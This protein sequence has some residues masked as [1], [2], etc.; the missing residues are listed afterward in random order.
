MSE[1]SLPVSAMFRIDAVCQAFEEAWQAAGEAGLRPRIEDYLGAT[2]QPERDALLGELLKVELHYRRGERPTPEEYRQRF[3]QD[4]DLIAQVFEEMASVPGPPREGGSGRET[5]RPAAAQQTGTDPNRT[6]PESP[7]QSPQGGQ[8]AGAATALPA[9]PGY[10][11]QGVLGRGGMGV[12]YKARDVQLNRLVALKMIL[13]GAH[14]GPQELAR[15]RTEAKAVARLQHP[16]VVQ[17]HEVGEHDG[18]PYFSLEFV[19]GGSL[20]KKLAGAPQQPGAAAQ[21]LETLARAVHAAHERGIVHRDL[22]P[23]NVLLTAD[24]VPKVTD[25]GLAKH[26]DDDSGGTLSGAILG[27]P[28]YMAPEQAAGRTKEIGPLSDV[29]ALGAILYEM[30]T[31]SPPFKGASVRDTLEQVC[32]QEPVPPRQL[33]PKV[34]RDLETICLKCLQKEP[35]RR[36]GSA[37]EL[38]ED[39]RR[40]QAG[41]PIQ[42]R[43]VGSAERAWRWCRR[44]PVVAGLLTAVAATLVVGS[45][46]ATY[47]AIQARDEAGHARDNEWRAEEE[48][49]NALASEKQA[50][51]AKGEAERARDQKDRQLTRAEGLVYAGRIERAQQYWRAGDVAAAQEQ[52]DRCRWDYRGWEHDY[53][54][55][56]FNASHLTLRGHTYAVYSVC[57]S[58]D[59]RRLASAS[60]HYGRGGEVK[61]WDAQTGQELLSLQGHGAGHEVTGVCFSPDGRRLASASTD[62]TVK[63]WN[64]Q[65]GQE[66]QTLKGHRGSVLSVCFSPDSR[67]L[68]SAS[69][70]TVKVWD[71]QTG[72]ELLTLEGAYGCVCFSPDG[73]RLASAST[74][75]TVKVWDAHTGREQRT[76]RLTTPVVHSVCFSPDGRRLAGAG[77]DG[78]RLAGAGGMMVKVWDAQTGQEQ[79]TLRGHTGEVTSV[80]F[81]PD[82]R[83]LAT[84]SLDRTVKVWDAQTGQEARSLQGHTMKVRSV[85]FSPDGRRLASAGGEPNEPGEVK[86]WDAQTGQ[87]QFSLQGAGGPVCFSP[88][89]RRLASASGDFRSRDIRKGEVKVWDARTGQEALSL[90]GHTGIVTSVC[91]SPDGRRLASASGGIDEQKRQGYGEVK[92]WDAQTGQELLSLQGHTSLVW[93]VCFSPDGRRLASAGGGDEVKVW[94]AQTGQELLTLEGAFGCV[95]FSPDGRRLATASADRTVRLWD[96]QTGQELL[97]LEGAI[98]CVCFSPD[99]RRLATASWDQTVKVWD[100]QTGQ[101]QLTLQGHTGPVTG[102]CFSPDGR[103]LASGSGDLFNLGNAW[104]LKV[105]DAQTGQETRPLQGHTGP[106][107]SV[108][109]SADGTRVVAA[110]PLGEVRSWDA[111]AGQLVV[112]DLGRGLTVFRVRSWDA[113]TGQLVVPCTDP[114]PPQPQAVS[115]DGQRVVRIDRGQPVVEPRAL[116][117]GDLFR[118]RLADPVGTHLWHLRLTREAQD[119]ADAFALAFHLEPLLLTSF[120]QRGARPRDA[121]PLWAVRPPLTRAPAGAAE[122]PVP[123]TEAEVQRLHDALSRR[124]DAEPKAWSLWAARGWSRHL[125]GDLAGAAAD[126]KRAAALQADEPG[127]WAVLG[128]VYLKHHQT[129]QAEGV[130]RKLAGSAG[131]DVAIWH[132]VEA[133]ACEQEGDWATAWWHVDH[134]LAGLP[135]PCP[136]LLVRRGRIALELGR[137]HDAAR[138]Y[139]AAVGLGRADVDTLSWSARV[140]LASGDREGYRQARAALLRQFDP[141]R[142]PQN[143][144]WV[145]RTALLGSA[146]GADL[147]PLREGLPSWWADPAAQAT[148]FLPGHRVLGRQPNW[149]T[150][151]PAQIRGG[152]LLRLGR[153]AQA[154]AE[155]QRASAQRSPGEA[156][157]ADLLLAIAQQKQGQTAAAR[158]TLERARFLLDPEAPARQAAGLLGGGTAGPWGVTAAAGQA[159]AA[160]PPRWDWTTRLEVRILRRE[161][162][163]ALGEH[164]R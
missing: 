53:L 145:A 156:P 161:A 57:F 14:A 140:C 102:V 27:T 129:Q 37:A 3:L 82:G 127:L 160:A 40:F 25:F 144:T 67:R 143:A 122:G 120:T 135:A 6:A 159:L 151:S 138:D 141:Q 71:A 137:D 8:A 26:L 15:F 95:C 65:T 51:E 86:V 29:Y 149:W 4:A 147:D 19:D 2:I 101:E 136:Q 31:G 55:T 72:Q 88:D 79:R 7:P 157:V 162:E 90:K 32:S 50:Q 45:A 103:R 115:P 130:C 43:P 146:A 38:A 35:R 105:W 134:W 68:A 114:P 41:E 1:R 63:V 69:D 21:L 123:L 75:R 23:A 11:V 39:Q 18:L 49:R 132:S 54:H 98:G 106:V 61:V 24:G 80:C 17:I 94:D 84:A 104:E 48:A 87:D 13:A 113:H 74:D 77:G 107:T 44:N 100:A 148:P 52:L 22:K 46:V 89:G 33:Q 92:V 58:P 64:A 153:H 111:H 16:N 70:R 124:L 163:E 36:Y 93:C 91:F 128:T 76:L 99:G 116:H 126:L 118:Q 60:G 34:P 155:L 85:C 139:A 121:F 131:I 62:R 142:D 164:R 112:S 59:G 81:S 125:L 10:E 119:G 154:V 73:R 97:T 30:L 42:A 83:R 150:D 110:N 9:I 152:L 96:A 78:R 56:L 133:N 28:S 20:H 108:G 117:T 158:R 12:V 66:R 109:F 5:V 47:F